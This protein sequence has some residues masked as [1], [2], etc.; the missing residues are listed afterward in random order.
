MR[1]PTPPAPLPTREGGEGGRLTS[2]SS[3]PFPSREGGR[4][5]GLAAV[6]FF[7]S[8]PCL[9]QAPA[10]GP[11][12]PLGPGDP[13]P[14]LTLRAE[15]QE[16]VIKPGGARTVATGNV[17][18]TFGDVRLRADRLEYDNATLGMIATGN[19]VLLRGDER[20]SGSSF[21]FDPQNA[22]G[23]AENAVAVSPPFYVAGARIERTPTGIIAQNAL[24]TACPEGKGE[25][26]LTA[27]QIELVNDRYVVLR[28]PSFYLF[29]TRLLTLPRYRFVVTRGRG[30][31]REEYALSIPIRIRSS[32]IAGLVV[33]VSVPYQLGGGYGGE[34]GVDL[35]SKQPIQYAVTLRRDFAGD[36]TE[37][38]GRTQFTDPTRRETTPSGGGPRES[39]LRTFLRARPLPPPLDPVLDYENIL[40]SED[41]VA[42]PTRVPA[43]GLRGEVNVLVNR[44]VGNKRQTQL[45]LS[46]VPEARLVGSLPLAGQVPQSN[47]AARAYLRR[48]RALF[49]GDIAVGRYE[50]RE[51]G[52]AR[53]NTA[54]S[55]LSASVGLGTL[56]LLLGDRFLVRP[57]FLMS[58]NAYQ[59]G[60]SYRVAEVNLAGD[61]VFGT[62]TAVGA[63]YIR[64][65]ASGQTPFTFDVVDTQNEAQLRAQISLAG[66]RYSLGTL[67]R[68]DADQRRFFDFQVALALRLRCI[69]PRL[70]YRR[71]GQSIGFTIG[72]PGLAL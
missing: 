3:S 71:L 12:R 27:R 30:R 15:D 14:R 9:A 28:R 37:D 48:P 45:L 64:R 8:A 31:E 55:R 21:L 72:L 53:R 69:E 58:Y 18:F 34:V 60:S 49:T 56:P 67:F 4:G 32:Q 59:G 13:L 41:P 23:I 47:D 1:E 10:A 52:A 68:F 26:R 42:L 2:T 63:S 22:V 36:Q 7:L 17:L 43:R 51:L 40:P 39:P 6:V 16:I 62:R 70:T 35:P 54:A 57:Q 19:V 11:S 66:G 61:Y 65:F 50:E 46:H 29:G 38:P 44:E 33:G 5:A 25:F 20:V 24:I